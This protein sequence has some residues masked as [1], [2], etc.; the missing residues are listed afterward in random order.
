MRRPAGPGV[1]TKTRGHEDTKTY[2]G[3]RGEDQ[4]GSAAGRSG[5]EEDVALSAEGHE[6]GVG[7]YGFRRVVDDFPFDLVM[8]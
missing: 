5:L 6:G 7:L 4:A 8:E 2:E 1:T 3:L